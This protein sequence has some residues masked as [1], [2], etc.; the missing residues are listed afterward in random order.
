LD[1]CE[2]LDPYQQRSINTLVRN[3]RFPVS[4]VV[5]YVGAFFES[6]ETFIAQQ[7][8]TE[9]DRRVIS[10]D[11]R[12]DED[13]R[14][15]CQ[16]VVSLRLLFSVSECVRLEFAPT[17]ISEF[18]PLA[19]RLGWRDVNDVM[20]VIAQR[21]ASPVAGRLRS[22]ATKLKSALMRLSKRHRTRFAKKAAELPFYEAYLLLLWQGRED[23]F[24]TRFTGED[25]AK[26][27]DLAPQLTN[28]AFEAWLRRKQRAALLHFAS[29]L[30]FRRLPLGGEGIVV[31]LA[32]G[33]IRDFLEILGE[34]FEAYARR[35]NLDSVDPSSLDRFATSRTQIAWDTQADGVAAAS[36]SYQTSI[37]SRMELDSDVVLRLIDGLGH[38]TSILQSAPDDPSVL[39]RAE[40]GVFVVRFSSST[41]APS[42]ATDLERER[43]VWR[44][45]RQAEIAGYIRTVEL[46]FGDGA[47]ARQLDDHRGRTIIFRLH[48]RFAPFYRFSYRGAYEHV[49]MSPSDVWALCDRISPA[50][51]R[52]WAESMAARYSAVDLDQLHL[53]LS[54]ADYGG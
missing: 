47:D 6:T 44:A 37:S 14:E 32:D 43:A 41:L 54:G 13:F 38:Y 19:T 20:A 52:I 10:L 26:L 36:T 7:P 53:P 18:F 45:I 28:P 11:S 22:A 3:S 8:L 29:V 2:V 12:K 42:N 48:R 33:S 35:Q 25:E 50:E 31:S 24:K 16:A 17:R 30:G 34:I 46:R 39:G 1:D 9:A 21:S 40:R 49:A 5:S 27:A 51:P 23:A 4:W 15:L